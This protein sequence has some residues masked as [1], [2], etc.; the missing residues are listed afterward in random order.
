MRAGVEGW[1][2]RLIAFKSGQTRWFVPGH[3]E[4]SDDPLPPLFPWPYEWVVARIL[5][6]EERAKLGNTTGLIFEPGVS[7]LSGAAFEK[8]HGVKCS[9]CGLI[10]QDG[11]EANMPHGFAFPYCDDCGPEIARLFASKP[12]L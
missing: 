2:G 8:G 12:N 1:E 10:M 11:A 6:Q 4:G 7:S 3:G 9:R 5:T